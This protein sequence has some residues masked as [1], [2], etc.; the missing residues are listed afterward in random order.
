[1]CK[2]FSMLS[3]KIV[4]EETKSNKRHDGKRDTIDTPPALVLTNS[5]AP[6]VRCDE[7]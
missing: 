3:P 1:M 4:G 5:R 2:K 7:I 6:P